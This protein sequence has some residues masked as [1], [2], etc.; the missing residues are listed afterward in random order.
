MIVREMIHS[1]QEHFV[2]ASVLIK[3][4]YALEILQ[5]FSFANVNKHH[6]RKYTLK[7]THL[8]YAATS[9]YISPFFP[10][11][12]QERSDMLDQF[13]TLNNLQQNTRIL[14][15]PICNQFLPKL[16]FLMTLFTSEGRIK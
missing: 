8:S 15:R 7:I 6:L 10:K 3:R 5:L 4:I 16:D 1:L 12:Q 11:L 9:N 14:S 13:L 2:G